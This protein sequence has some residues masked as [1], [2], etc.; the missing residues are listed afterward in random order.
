[1][2]RM[3]IRVVLD[4][5]LSPRGRCSGSEEDNE[6]W[7]GNGIPPVG[8]PGMGLGAL[9][10]AEAVVGPSDEG[11]EQ[12]R[13]VDSGQVQTRE[14]PKVFQRNAEYE[15]P[16]RTIPSRFSIPKR[17]IWELDPMQS[18]VQL[19]DG[20]LLYIP[21]Q[22]SGFFSLTSI[23]LEKGGFVKRTYDCQVEDKPIEIL[24]K[25]VTVVE[26]SS[27]R[28]H[29]AGTCEFRC[30]TTHA[31]ARRK[32]LDLERAELNMGGSDYLAKNGRVDSSYA[33]TTFGSLFRVHVS[34]LQIDMEAS[35]KVKWHTDEAV[36]IADVEFDLTKLG[37]EKIRPHGYFHPDKIDKLD[38]FSGSDDMEITKVFFINVDRN[39]M[40]SRD[41]SLKFQTPSGSRLVK[42]GEG[43]DE[44]EIDVK[45]G[46]LMEWFDH[47]NTDSNCLS[48]SITPQIGGHDLDFLKEVVEIQLEG[49]IAPELEFCGELVEDYQ[50]FLVRSEREHRA[51][52]R[53]YGIED[54]FI[55]Q[56]WTLEEELGPQI[57][58]INLNNIYRRISTGPNQP[59]DSN[60][61][62][63][64]KL[65][66]EVYDYHPDNVTLSGYQKIKNHYGRGW[67]VNV[68]S[69]SIQ[70]LRPRER[71]SLSHDES[72]AY[73]SMNEA[74][75][76]LA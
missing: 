54:M 24:P 25:I 37:L 16:T 22:S 8:T 30:N 56:A 63:T 65:L 45:K 6:K 21:R 3:L 34:E 29:P 23:I 57:R 73:F 2:A 1:M 20:D 14:I 41:V 39:L 38:L 4:S 10:W 35:A 69:T 26:W 71:F 28:Y 62:D 15:L 19:E 75:K 66:S 70:V 46:K 64:D 50:R 60:C 43:T 11:Q 52:G 13:L 53:N 12:I 76:L 59:P 74:K 40:K 55:D 47:P 49:A 9:R 18:G 72:E 36:F 68:E 5:R 33:K 27:A 32:R 61:P 48:I 7:D 44:W 42:P 67:D 51:F 58:R 17:I 31:L